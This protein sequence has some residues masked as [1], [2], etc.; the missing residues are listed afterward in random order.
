MPLLEWLLGASAE[1]RGLN[2]Q[3]LDG[4]TSV[5]PDVVTRPGEVREP[6]P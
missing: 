2:W 4:V 1:A 5:Q 3:V 6:W